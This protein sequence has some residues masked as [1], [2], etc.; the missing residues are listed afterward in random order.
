MPGE[1][2]S[3][4]PVMSE[5][6]KDEYICLEITFSGKMIPYHEET[7]LPVFVKDEE[8]WKYSK[9]MPFAGMIGCD[10]NVKIKIAYMGDSITQGIGTKSNSYLHWNAIFS[11]KFGNDYSYW[12]LGIRYGKE[13]DDATEGTWL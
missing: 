4:D 10:R 2:F 8:K 12:N 3:S 7:L 1:F 13:K 11:E 5:F 9:F 6:E